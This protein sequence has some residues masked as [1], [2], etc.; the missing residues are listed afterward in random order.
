MPAS[1]SDHTN[2]AVSVVISGAGLVT[3][4]GLD[5]EETWRALCA[6]KSG[7]APLTAVESPLSPNKGGGQAPEIPAEQGCGELRETAYLRRAITEALQAADCL[8]DLPYPPSRC[9]VLIGTTL[10]GMRQA[11]ACIRSNDFTP[12]S[13]FLA[14]DILRC[15]TEALGLRGLASSTCSACSSGL[16]SIAM[17]ETLLRTGQFDLVV[18]GGYD[19]I[20]EYAYGGFNSM[21]LITAGRIRNFCRGRDGMKLGEGYGVVVL[22]RATDAARRGVR[23]LAAVL[24]YGESCDA[25]HLSKP[26]PRTLVPICLHPVCPHD[27][28]DKEC[29]MGH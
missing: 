2:E 28:K 18:A 29:A 1:P 7:I 21:R 23:P 12:L 9:G 24:G 17:A 4:L 14:G 22:E 5:V 19:P 10:H 11:G 26:H 13:R 16:A 25:Y 6:G 15:A 3:S 27:A 20:S 8:Q